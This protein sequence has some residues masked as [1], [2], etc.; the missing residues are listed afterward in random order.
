MIQDKLNENLNITS[1]W[2]KENY[3]TLNLKKGK[4]EGMVF[5]TKKKDPVELSISGTIINNTES[6]KYLGVTLD[7]RLSMSLHIDCTFKKVSSRIKLLRKVRHHLSPHVAEIVFKSMILPL[8]LYCSNT[9]LLNT[10]NRY[11]LL[12]DRAF[13]I[14]FE[15]SHLD[16][17]RSIKNEMKRRCIIEIFKI[18]NNAKMSNNFFEYFKRI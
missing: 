18:L 7:T 17:W 15:F 3:L 12:Q 2:L 1:K 5:S 13:K 16:N 14:V 11:Q 6:Y 9:F 8:M 4:T 10:V